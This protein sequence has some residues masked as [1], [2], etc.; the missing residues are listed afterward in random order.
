MTTDEFEFIVD[1][2]AAY[3]VVDEISPHKVND[4]TY[5]FAKVRES[6]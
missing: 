4:H 3:V 5:L 6:K 1:N 2:N